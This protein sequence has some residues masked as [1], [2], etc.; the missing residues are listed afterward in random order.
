[1][2]LCVVSPPYF[3]VNQRKC[4]V[5]FKVLFLLNGFDLNFDFSIF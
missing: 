4:Q 2:L 3:I 5:K 1:M